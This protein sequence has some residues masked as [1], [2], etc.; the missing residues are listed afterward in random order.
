MA[1]FTPPDPPF[2]PDDPTPPPT[3]SV[4][5]PPPE[6]GEGS[7]W[8]PADSENRDRILDW[9]RMWFRRVFFPW[10][11]AFTTWLDTQWNRLATFINTWI[12]AADEY[13]TEHAIA[14][15]SFRVTSTPIAP[16]G[17]TNVEI[18]EG[19]DAEHRPLVVGDLVLDETDESNYGVITV[20]IDD[21]HATVQYLGSL[22]GRA[23]H[24]WWVTATPIS[25]VGTTDVVLS[26]ES[27][28]LPQVNDLVSDES[29]ALRYGIITVVADATHV[30]VSP[31]G[32]LRGLPG[33]GW[34]GTTTVIAHGGTTDVVLSSGPDR[35]PQINDLVVDETA[36]SAYGEITVVTDA[37]HVTVAYINTLQGPA[38]TN[39]TNGTDGSDG[40]PGVVQSVVAGTN[41]T[42]DSTDPANPIVSATG[43]G[44]GGGVDS[45]VAG[46]NISVDDTDP[47]NPV[48]S[49]I[50]L[51]ESII[52]GGHITVDATDPENPIVSASGF[53]ESIVAGSNVS[54][55]STDPANP[56]VNASGVMESIT[57]DDGTITIDNTDPANPVVSAGT[58][59]T[60]GNGS[61]PSLS[62]ASDPGSHGDSFGGNFRGF[63]VPLVFNNLTASMVSPD[64]DG[65]IFFYNGGGTITMFAFYGGTYYS[66]ELEPI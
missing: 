57:N 63:I 64:D 10:I 56:I 25:A 12:T 33:F 24:G 8:A 23:G 40:A 14:G 47:A 30:T 38:G 59:E 34:W 4:P 49:T 37:T 17:T 43:G 55:D 11:A 18:A 5:L 46:Y 50:S 1:S 32:V 15:Y 13:I 41:V 39:G 31:L 20:V 6:V 48:V 21:T 66:I 29:S 54:V 2:V 27:D 35:V 44:G 51:V 58:I 7:P 22:K 28:R 53:V 19:L 45:V 36:S 16:E 52:A 42:V 60:I 62:F 3:L 61:G 65:S 9:W 26:A